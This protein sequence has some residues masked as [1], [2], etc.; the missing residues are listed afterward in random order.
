MPDYLAQRKPD[1]RHIRLKGAPAM[2]PGAPLVRK[3]WIE[4]RRGAGSSRPPTCSWG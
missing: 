4:R 2:T 1:R 3:E